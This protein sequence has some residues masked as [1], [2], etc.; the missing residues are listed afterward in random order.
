MLKVFKEV[1]PDSMDIELKQHFGSLPEDERQKVIEQ[2][3][4][5][6]YLVITQPHG[7]RRE[8]KYTAFCFSSLD[9]EYVFHCDSD[10][11]VGPESL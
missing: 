2:V 1:F 11:W 10:T 4:D 6:K 8:V 3:R 5:A 7:G 9:T